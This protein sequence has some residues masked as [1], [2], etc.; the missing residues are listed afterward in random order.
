MLVPIFGVLLAK[1]FTLISWTIIYLLV[2]KRRYLSS[3]EQV[4]FL[5]FWVVALSLYIGFCGLEFF[6]LITLLIYISAIL[7][8]FLFAFLLIPLDWSISHKRLETG[9][10]S[11]YYL[12][13]N[14]FSCLIFL[15]L[16]YGIERIHFIRIYFLDAY[17]SSLR[18]FS[19]R[20]S[21]GVDG[22]SSWASVT[23]FQAHLDGLL[24][25]LKARSS[26]TLAVSMYVE[27]FFTVG[28]IILALILVMVGTLSWLRSSTSYAS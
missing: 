7:I 16:V 15:A 6:V 8:L 12:Y 19:N 3:S 23:G 28:L 17:E 20:L 11:H 1:S 10:S 14:I 27:N 9:D 25:I 24:V 18:R 4:L 21:H 5:G 13:P 22:F 26:T 2:F